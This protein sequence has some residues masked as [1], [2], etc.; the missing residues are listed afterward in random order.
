MGRSTVGRIAPH[1]IIGQS[2]DGNKLTVSGKLDKY[3]DAPSFTTSAQAE[4][5]IEGVYTDY[6]VPSPFSTDFRYA[7]FDAQAPIMPR[8]I[9]LLAGFKMAAAKESQACSI[10]LH[11]VEEEP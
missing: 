1:G 8:N 11:G 9:S 10:E 4:G 2:F 3:G 6:I 5:A 7:R